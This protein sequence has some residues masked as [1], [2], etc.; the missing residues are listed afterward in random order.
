MIEH[1]ERRQAQRGAIISST[2]RLVIERGYRATT[3]R[4]IADEAG[5]SASDVYNQFA[6]KEKILLDYFQQKL[7][8]AAA[9][10]ELIE[11]IDEYSLQEKIHL[12]I[13]T[14][15]AEILPDR[16]LL[17]EFFKAAMARPVL[18]LRAVVPA[19]D[20]YV[21]VVQRY[22]DGAVMSGQIQPPRLSSRYLGGFMNFHVYVVAFW[23]R[24]ESEGFE[25]TTRLIDLG[26]GALVAALTSGVI[27]DTLDLGRFVVRRSL[28]L[29]LDG[30]GALLRLAGDRRH[31]TLVGDRR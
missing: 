8:D 29:P 27:D 30:A 21:D 25:D 15:L 31:R 6:S 1:E 22:V 13:E 10:V 24:D 3:I 28:R 26:V 18:S 23:L 4:A 19:R 5:V 17:P 11:D 16:E 12:F 2:V 20:F 9:A 14:H 7:E